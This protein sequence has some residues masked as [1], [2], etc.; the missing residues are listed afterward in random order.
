MMPACLPN[1]AAT[2]RSIS[3]TR[4]PMVKLV[5]PPSRTAITASFSAWSWTLP[6]YKMR[7]M[8]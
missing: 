2:W 6:E 1:S 4:S 7:F 5:T 3:A 8:L